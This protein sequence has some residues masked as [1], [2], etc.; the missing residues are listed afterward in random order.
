M[1]FRDYQTACTI[2]LLENPCGVLCL[3]PGF[4]KTAIILEAYKLARTRQPGKMLVIAPLRVATHSW[5]EEIAKWGFP[6]NPVVYLGD[7]RTRKR[8]QTTL[9]RADVI[10]TSYEHMGE[11][12]GTPG[13]RYL[14]LDEAQKIKST[15]S[16]RFKMLK[17]V[18]DCFPYRWLLTGTPIP[19]NVQDLFNLGYMVSDKVFGKTITGFRKTYMFTIDR[20]RGMY[21]LKPGAMEKISRAFSEVSASL[22]D[23]LLQDMPE[24]IPV[25]VSIELQDEVWDVYRELRDSYYVLVEN[26][27]VV[28]AH[29]AVVSNKLRQVAAGFLYHEDHTTSVLH[30]EK[31]DAILQLIE[32][33]E[34]P[35]ILFV[36]FEYEKNLYREAIPGSVVLDAKAPES[37]VSDFREGRI[38]VLIGH[39][40]S[41]GEGLNLQGA[42]QYIIWA[43]LPWSHGMYTQAVGRLVRPGGR[44]TVVEYRLIVSGGIDEK[45]VEA[46]DT[47]RTIEDVILKEMRH[48]N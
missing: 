16:H 8:L 39:P 29:A 12:L 17:A 48:E 18:R 23:E 44:A 3:R 43:S 14:V 41:M 46:L 1:K 25:D 32:A 28:A 34:S 31:L 13:I 42:A 30:S 2:W 10:I 33:I 26:G 15:Q 6:F 5:P 27:P 7:V 37:V 19:N 36:Q 40:G 22:P 38:K 24:R 11:V 4:G 47:K 35:C 21:A 9:F 20:E 45:V